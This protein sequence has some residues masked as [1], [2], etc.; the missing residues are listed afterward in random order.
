MPHTG[1][2][3]QLRATVLYILQRYLLVLTLTVMTDCS[4]IFLSPILNNDKHRRRLLHT[5]ASSWLSL[6]ESNCFQI[7]IIVVFVVVVVVAS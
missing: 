4:D 6:I 5:S 3:G 7:I 1:P 2:I